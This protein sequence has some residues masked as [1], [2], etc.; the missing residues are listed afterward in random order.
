MP[1]TH[2]RN[3]KRGSDRLDETQL[4]ERMAQVPLKV[5]WFKQNGY[6]P[7]YYQLLFHTMWNEDR[8][9]RFRHLVAGRRGGKTLAAAWDVLFY[10]LHPQAF[11]WDVHATEE[12]RPLHAWVLTADYP[13]GRAAWRTFEEVMRTAGLQLGKDYHQNKADKWFEFENGSLIEFRSADN[14][15][16]LR[17]A[18]LDILWM[19]EAAFIP[20]E[21]AYQRARPALADKVGIV[22]TTTT[23]SGKNW[24]YREFWSD[25]AM[26]DVKQGRVEYWS[27]DNPYFSKEEWEYLLQ[28]YHP[29]MFKREFMAAFD[30]MAGRE[31]SGE[32]LKYYTLGEP[33]KDEIT[34][35]RIHGRPNVLD[36]VYYMGVDPAISLSDRADHFAMALVGVSK[37]NSQAYLIDTF[38][39]R[40]PFH[41]QLMK[42]AEWN[43]RWHPR[44]IGIESVAFQAALE[45]QVA[46]LPGLPPT[47]PVMNRGRK[48][49]ERILGMAPLFQVGRI[50]VRTSHR[51]FIE[52]WLD[53]DSEVKNPQD[54]LLDATEI[55]ISIVGSLLPPRIERKD[56]WLMPVVDLNEMARRDQPGS[57]FRKDSREVDEHMGADW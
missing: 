38:K 28:H 34:V 8:L 31:L 21:D 12:V 55:A 10:L 24:L 54:D 41:E 6:E 22:C 5:L 37:D 20:N 35:P 46:R 57:K 3:V 19:D 52:E 47:V 49:E 51:D 7:H 36:L 23:P 42:I 26:A 2:V 33:Q 18:G 32:W 45:Q 29:L 30:A 4:Y 13:L 17:G 27:I 48:K 16:S 9:C 14:P 39:G 50:R 43:Q 56:D 1:D 40:L 44:V 53:Y 25:S 15:E 11:H